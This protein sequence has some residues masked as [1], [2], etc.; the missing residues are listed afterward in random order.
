MTKMVILM[1][2]CTVFSCALSVAA[3]WFVMKYT[4][5]DMTLELD[6]RK[7]YSN[8]GVIAY[9]VLYLIIGLLAG[10]LFF[11]Y[12]YSI[13]EIIRRTVVILLIIAIARIDRRKCVIPNMAV[14][15][16]LGFQ[17]ILLIA[18][19]FADRNNWVE[20]LFSSLIGLFIGGVTFLVGYIISRQGM[21][22]GDVK[23]LSA[24]GFCLGDNTIVAIIMISLLLAAGYGITQLIRKKKKYKDEMPFAPFVA[25]A[26]TILLLL[27]F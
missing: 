26:T 12:Q 15:F 27:G 25:I 18:E 22:L 3:E 10:F 21:G 23:L 19:F 14:V 9:S 2:V 1:L 17:F 20:V 5:D 11:N 16:L 4:N 13:T 24:M 7:H 8:K 6:I